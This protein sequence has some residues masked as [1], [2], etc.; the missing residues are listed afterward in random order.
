[1]P[2]QHLLARPVAAE[3]R[4]HLRD[5][6]V[7]L[8]DHQ[9]PIVG[10][11]VEQRRRRLARLLAREVARIVLDAATEAARHQRLEVEHRALLEPL[12]FEQA[13]AF[14]QLLQPLP[15][16]DSDGLAG[17]RHHFR[18]RHEVRARIDVH[19]ID[20]SQH[21]AAQRVDDL[22]RLDL[23]APERD[24]DRLGVFTDRH[25]VDDVTA[26]AEMTARQLDLVALVLHLDKALEQLASADLLPDL[27]PEAHRQVVDRGAEAVDARHRRHDD[28]VA[29][30]E[31]GEG[32]GVPHPVDLLVDEG[33]LLDVGIGRRD[34]GF[35][36]VV[37]V[38]AD[39]V[40]DGIVRQEALQLCVQLRR[41]GLVRREDQRRSLRGSDDVGHREGLARAGDA[42]QHLP[43]VTA[44]QTLH[45]LVDR[46]RLVAGRREGREEIE[47]WHGWLLNGS[48][49]LLVTVAGRVQPVRRFACRLGDLRC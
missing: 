24:A 44:S 15:Q 31:Q 28:D 48:G 1:M 3:H 38:I 34:I 36:L 6:D 11:I 39:E 13:P 33:V 40:F 19:T 45:Q 49:G 32:R 12:R 7:A 21:A 42:Q 18:R 20:L 23:V 26:D 25:H 29:P 10:E 35:G 14:A 46:G 22:Q 47:G 41:E 37:V 27:Q 5:G 9:Q 8:V 4:R 16:L 30:L 17:A 43:R 2:D